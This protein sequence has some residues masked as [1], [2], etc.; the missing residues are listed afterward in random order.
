[1]AS[2]KV[3]SPGILFPRPRMCRQLSIHEGG[4]VRQPPR[5]EVNEAWLLRVWGTRGTGM[6]ESSKPWMAL[7]TYNF[8]SSMRKTTA[9]FWNIS[10]NF[11]QKTLLNCLPP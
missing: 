3:P 2:F 7:L 11:S 10:I 9:R 6:D 8:A 4:K 5:S 1:M